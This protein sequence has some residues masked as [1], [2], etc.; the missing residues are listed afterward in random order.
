M[1]VFR[2][3]YSSAGLIIFIVILAAARSKSL[4]SFK[5]LLSLPIFISPMRA[6][7]A[8]CLSINCP[9]CFNGL[10]S[11]LFRSRPP[12]GV[13]VVLISEKIDVES[14]FKYGLEISRFS[15]LF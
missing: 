10:V 12:I 14:F 4:M 1:S 6:L 5:S 2:S 15:R 9:P 13:F 8:L 7:T 11:H 3:E